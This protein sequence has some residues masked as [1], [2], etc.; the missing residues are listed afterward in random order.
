MT[1]LLVGFAAGYIVH[2]FYGEHINL[3]ATKLLDRITG[4]IKF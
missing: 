3:A 2:N 1:A 4:K